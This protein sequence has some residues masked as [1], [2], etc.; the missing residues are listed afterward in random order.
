MLHF[1]WSISLLRNNL[2]LHWWEMWFICMDR[3]AVPLQMT[4]NVNSWNKGHINQAIQSK[5]IGMVR[6]WR[7]IW[8]WKVTDFYFFMYSLRKDLNIT[9]GKSKTVN[10]YRWDNTMVNKK[11]VKNTM[12]NKTLHRKLKIEQHKSYKNSGWRNSCAPEG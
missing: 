5:Y 10:C 12:I 7:G 9:N 8:S 2:L 1:R 3:I 11:E 6:I 4:G